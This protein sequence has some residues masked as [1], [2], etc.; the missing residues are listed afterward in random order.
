MR[1]NIRKSSIGNIITRFWEPWPMGT[2]TPV[3][4]IIDPVFTK[5]S[6]NARFLL[7]ENERF[8]LV[9]VKTGSIN[10]GTVVNLS[11][12]AA[13]SSFC[14][15]IYSASA[16]HSLLSLKFSPKSVSPWS[17]STKNHTKVFYREQCHKILRTLTNGANDIGARIYRPGFREN[18]PKT[19][20]FSH[21]KGA[22]WACFR[23]MN[24]GT[25]VSASLAF[26]CGFISLAHY[27]RYCH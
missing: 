16:L 5:T 7:S 8:G 23:D 24:S 10:S 1:L 17:T 11:K 27:I 26:T 13:S 3:P 20:V 9:F 4:E 18:K 19:F 25:V 22:F 15:W 2:T 12:L 6:Q 21:W 14:L